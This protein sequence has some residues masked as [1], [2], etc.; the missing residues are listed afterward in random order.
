MSK[1][2]IDHKLI[3]AFGC[4]DKS[5]KNRTTWYFGEYDDGIVYG[6]A[7]Q[8][9]ADFPFSYPNM[10]KAIDAYKS[11]LE[12]GCIPMSDEQIKKSFGKD[13]EDA[14]IGINK[15][16]MFTNKIATNISN[17]V[18]KNYKK[19]NKFYIPLTF[20]LILLFLIII[21]FLIIYFGGRIKMKKNI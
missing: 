15:I 10:K 6:A 5:K 3:R 19:I 20:G 9:G 17:K 14:I 12:N 4:D 18:K 1:K 8:N 13:I 7:F 21:I 2:Q 16:E 11:L